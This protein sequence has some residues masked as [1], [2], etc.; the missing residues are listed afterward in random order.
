MVLNF[1]PQE[2]VFCYGGTCVYNGGNIFR[3]TKNLE[4][5]K[6]RVAFTMVYRIGVTFLSLWWAVFYGEKD[7]GAKLVGLPGSA[8]HLPLL[9]SHQPRIS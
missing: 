4:Y 1:N 9:S 6:I 3:Q 2:A 5:D 7:M 8:V